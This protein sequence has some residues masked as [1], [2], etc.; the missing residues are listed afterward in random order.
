MFKKCLLCHA[1]RSEASHKYTVLMKTKIMYKIDFKKASANLL[2]QL[3]WNISAH[4]TSANASRHLSV[5][6][7]RAFST[8]K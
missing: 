1:E 4:A 8:I 5:Y 7:A 3:N 6:R 2:L